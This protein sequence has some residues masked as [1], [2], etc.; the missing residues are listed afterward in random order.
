[1]PPMSTCIA[2]IDHDPACRELL[3]DL[4][5]EEGYAAARREAR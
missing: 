1:M 2:V 3:H 5:S 4:L